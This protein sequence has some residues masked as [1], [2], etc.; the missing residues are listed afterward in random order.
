MSRLW[1]DV[2]QLLTCLFS[3]PLGPNTE[4]S[5]AACRETTKSP[6]QTA[7]V[8]GV[9][10]P[11]GLTTLVRRH[12]LL[13]LADAAT[14]WLN[15]LQLLVDQVFVAPSTEPMESALPSKVGLLAG[16]WRRPFRFDLVATEQMSPDNM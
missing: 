16:R 11:V 2:F 15:V 7:S 1:S 9:M 10:A 12:L 13:P 5:S 14:D 8:T 3:L 6:I 4:G